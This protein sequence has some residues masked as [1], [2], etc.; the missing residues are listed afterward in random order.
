MA[1]LQYS[2][3]YLVTTISR[4]SRRITEEFEQRARLANALL[5]TMHF[6]SPENISKL[7]VETAKTNI[8]QSNLTEREKEILKAWQDLGHE[9]F[10]THNYDM[11]RALYTKI[12]GLLQQ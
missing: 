7:S 3:Y 4:S 5:D 9:L 10:I 2:V 6:P 8:E 11:A 12:S 1:T